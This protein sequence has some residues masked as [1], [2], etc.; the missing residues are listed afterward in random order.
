MALI[1]K[2]ASR[3]FLQ[4]SELLMLNIQ[5]I[6]E[7]ALKLVDVHALYADLTLV[8]LAYGPVT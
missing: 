8:A 3:N 6:F 1:K 7:C 4:N 2:A 5:L